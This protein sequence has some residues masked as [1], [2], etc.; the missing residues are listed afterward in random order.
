MGEPTQ[1]EIPWLDKLFTFRICC[2][3]YA[4]WQNSTSQTESSESCI[5]LS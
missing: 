5:C 2:E 3:R 4:V 1:S